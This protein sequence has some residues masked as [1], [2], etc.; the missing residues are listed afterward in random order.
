LNQEIADEALAHEFEVGTLG[1]AQPLEPTVRNGE[2]LIHGGDIRLT[3]LDGTFSV[4]PSPTVA[5]EHHESTA[6]W[7]DRTVSMNPQAAIVIGV[8]A[9]REMSKKTIIRGLQA[10]M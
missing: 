5:V 8:M 6:R 4:S 3:L 1:E 10:C 7:K 2:A 9:A